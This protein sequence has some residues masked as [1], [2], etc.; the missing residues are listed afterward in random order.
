MEFQRVNR[1]DPETVFVTVKNSYSTATLTTGQWAAWDVT[2]DQDGVGVTKPAAFNRSA[3]GGVISESIA[4][5]EFGLMQI[6]GFRNEA[7][8]LGGSGYETSKISAGQPLHFATSG[9]GIQARAH[10]SAAVKAFYGDIWGFGMA[11]AN[12]AAIATQAGTSG[13]YKVLIR[14]M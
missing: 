2:T 13:A 8:G 5:N 4:H 6:W 1:S 12:T 9:F 10:N 3:K 11:P 14:C 7:R